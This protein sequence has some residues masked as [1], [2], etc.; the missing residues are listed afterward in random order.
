MK[1]TSVC[2]VLVG[3]KPVKQP[4]N[5]LQY[6]GFGAAPRKNKSEEWKKLIDYIPLLFYGSLLYKS[7]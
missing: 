1:Y 4:L 5:G 2:E 6:T 7:H 3:Q